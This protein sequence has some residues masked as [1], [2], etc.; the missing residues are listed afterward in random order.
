MVRTRL[1][2]AWRLALVQAS[3]FGCWCCNLS[4][5]LNE[6]PVGAI[7]NI[8]KSVDNLNASFMNIGC[9]DILLSP[10]PA[11]GYRASSLLRIQG[12]ESEP[13]TYY[14]CS[15]FCKRP[16]SRIFMTRNLGDLC[17]T[18]KYPMTSALTESQEPLSTE[19]ESKPAGAG[20][21]KEN[22]TFMITDDMEIY[23]TSTIKSIVLL[24]KLKVENMSD[25][26]SLEITVGVTQ[27]E[28]HASLSTEHASLD[29][30]LHLRILTLDE[31]RRWGST[32]L[33][34]MNES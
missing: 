7:S 22:T 26:D 32:V 27:V 21:V 5:G 34:T 16:G 14:I 3:S 30:P 1:A 20:Y 11:W 8:F 15:N 2:T 18:C 19:L 4:P 12:A 33:V 13:T 24:N 10:Q 23:P 25:L 17:P 28:S 29:L 31:L 9:K 6:W